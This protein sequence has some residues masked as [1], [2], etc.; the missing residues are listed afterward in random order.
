L[1]STGKNA[2][3]MHMPTPDRPDLTKKRQDSLERERKEFREQLNTVLKIILERVQALGIAP[4]VYL[5]GGVAF[6]PQL[7]E[8]HDDLDL[9][10]QG[11]TNAVTLY[12][13]LVH[14]QTP[15]LSFYSTDYE[16]LSGK[17]LYHLAARFDQSNTQLSL[18][19]FFVEPVANTNPPLWAYQDGSQRAI[20]ASAFS[21]ELV[22][23]VENA[24]QRVIPEFVFL[25]RGGDL[26]LAPIYPKQKG[27]DIQK[28]D[29]LRQALKKQGYLAYNGG[30]IF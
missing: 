13:D 29:Q 20:P 6:D 27:L 3:K 2:Y 23:V 24:I 4:S 21:P 22:T 1:S 18:D 28:I 5:H 8:G 30:P 17:I 16:G 7:H 26:L 15:G 10:I 25:A 19:L 9:M 11:Q 12:N 14:L